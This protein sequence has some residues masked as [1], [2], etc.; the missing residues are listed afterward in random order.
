MENTHKTET[1]E[2]IKAR[3]SEDRC[4][5]VA[6]MMSIMSNPIRFHILCALS[7][8]PFTV[9][10][11]VELSGARLSNVSQQLK[12]MTLA[13]YLV[14]ERRGKQIY[15][16]LQEKRISQLL[17]ELEKMFPVHVDD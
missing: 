6:R 16:Q 17:G 8:E 11:L 14:K 12:M 15:Y 7:F 13:G 5:Q 1:I 2:K 9:S 10:E 4:S 3:F